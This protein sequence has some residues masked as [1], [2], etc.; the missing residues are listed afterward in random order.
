MKETRQKMYFFVCTCGLRIFGR[1]WSRCVLMQPN[2]EEEVMTTV[3]EL[4]S[5]VKDVR[6]NFSIEGFKALFSP[7]RKGYTF[8]QSPDVWT[9]W[10]WDTLQMD[11]LTQKSSHLSHCWTALNSGTA[12]CKTCCQHGNVS[13]DFEDMEEYSRPE[14]GQQWPTGQ[15]TLAYYLFF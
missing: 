1:N 13:L 15:L 3:L 5:W 7:T 2:E 11:T 10:P 6:A 8:T 9:Y 14:F 4:T 12:D